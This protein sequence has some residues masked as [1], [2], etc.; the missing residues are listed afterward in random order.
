MVQTIVFIRRTMR[1]TST[2]VSNWNWDFS[3]RMTIRNIIVPSIFTA[4]RATNRGINRRKHAHVWDVSELSQ[5]L[6]QIKF[7]CSIDY[8]WKLGSFFFHD[9]KIAIFPKQS[10][11]DAFDYC[12]NKIDLLMLTCVRYFCSH[13]AGIHMVSLPMVSQLEE[14]IYGKYNY[15][16]KKKG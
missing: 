1:F 9:E 4:I 10:A 7:I 16:I 13:N 15:I 12:L 5:L 14:F 2:S 8:Q 11:F 6:S 3:L